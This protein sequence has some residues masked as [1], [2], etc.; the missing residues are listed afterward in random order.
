[1]PGV[2]PQTFVGGDG[3][4]ALMFQLG[5]SQPAVRREAGGNR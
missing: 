5:A 1:V 3:S 4:A 2:L